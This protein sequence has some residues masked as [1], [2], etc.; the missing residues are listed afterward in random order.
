MLSN[1]CE[2]GITHERKNLNTY[3]L[4]KNDS[5]STK[6]T[7]AYDFGYSVKTWNEPGIYL[8]DNYCINAIEST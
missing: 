8:A 7:V 1:V 5:N 4:N 2:T 3:F 6:I